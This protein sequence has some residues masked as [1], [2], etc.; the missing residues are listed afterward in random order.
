MKTLKDILEGVLDPKGVLDVSNAHSL[1]YPVPK[2]KDFEKN[3]FGQ[4]GVNIKWECPNIVQEYLD[5]LDPS[6]FN[7][8][9]HISKSNVTG[10]KISILNIYEMHVY[11]LGNDGSPWGIATELKG[12]G[13]G[14]TSMPKIKKDVIEF[15]KHVV[16]NP[17]S[18]KTLFEYCNKAEYELNTKNIVDEKT[19]KQILKY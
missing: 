3:M 4:G 11:L 7:G 5:V 14:C 2:I 18:L 9:K 6:L 1:V 12:I 19:F 16:N 8:F 10:F 15:F 17:D 13:T